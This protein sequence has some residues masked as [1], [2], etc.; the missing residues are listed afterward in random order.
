MD[1]KF[2][3]RLPARQGIQQ[4]RRK[5]C[6]ESAAKNRKEDRLRKQLSQDIP[7][8]GANGEADREF[9]AAVC[10]AR[11]KEVG[12]IGAGRKEDEK[13]QEHNSSQKGAGGGSELVTHPARFCQS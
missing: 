2:R 12:K 3:K 1:R 4:D 9:S 11:R 7:S 10:C 13:C 5:K 6:S 8:A